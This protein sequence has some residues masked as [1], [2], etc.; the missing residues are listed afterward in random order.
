MKSG[1][2]FLFLFLFLLHTDYPFPVHEPVQRSFSYHA[3]TFFL[4]VID[5]ATAEL[6][7]HLLII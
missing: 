5:D 4:F 6:P 3:F 2:L 7:L 1:F